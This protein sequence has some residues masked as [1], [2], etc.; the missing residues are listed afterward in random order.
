MYALALRHQKP[1]R[2]V[3]LTELLGEDHPSTLR[4]SPSLAAKRDPARPAS[5]NPICSNTLRHT[6]VRRACLAVRS[7]TRSANVA[8]GAVL[9][10]AEEPA[11]TKSQHHRLTGHSNISKPAV[12]TAVD[13][14]R[15][16]AAGRA[17]TVLH[18]D[19]LPHQH[20]RCG[21][22]DPLEH[23]TRQ[24]RQEHVQPLTIAQRA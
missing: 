23:H 13:P 6:E 18:L 8:A 24:V 14:A 7:P 12:I 4:T 5:A 10:A 11:H 2:D 20:A 16:A 9:V 21:L 22:L 1:A 3:V 15:S 17:D 19:T